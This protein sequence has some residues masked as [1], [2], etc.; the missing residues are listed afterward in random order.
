VLP[1]SATQDAATSFNCPKNAAAKGTNLWTKNYKGFRGTT[2]CNDGAVLHVS[3][4]GKPLSFS[5]GIC[6]S[7]G[8]GLHVA[9]GT[10]VS[11]PSSR[12]PTEPP[13]F[14]LQKAKAGTGLDNW[15]D[16]GTPK[17]QWAA[18]VKISWT[19][20]KGSFSGT[21]GQWINDKYTMVKA[22]GSFVCKR[23]VKSGF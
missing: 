17:V 13:G 16:I 5:G 19:G 9:S 6:T 12:K 20:L 18:K 10:H 7:D 22:S 21:T 8:N 15:A 4:A 1:R 23:I 14:S 11:P 2:W 3:V